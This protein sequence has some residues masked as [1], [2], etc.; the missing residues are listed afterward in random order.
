MKTK[1]QSM[2]RVKKGEERVG[3]VRDC[4]RFQKLV[5]WSSLGIEGEEG[6]KHL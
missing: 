3:G 1:T 4:R 6:L 5:V 2:T